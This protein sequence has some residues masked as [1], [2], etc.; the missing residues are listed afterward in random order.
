MWL[1]GGKSCPAK[2][3]IPVIQPMAGH[4]TSRAIMPLK[5]LTVSIVCFKACG[6]GNNGKVIITKC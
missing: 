6:D 5:G 4:V 1:H 2:K 3:G